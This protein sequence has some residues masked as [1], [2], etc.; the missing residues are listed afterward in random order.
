MPGIGSREA[1]ADL[2]ENELPQRAGAARQR[3]RDVDHRAAPPRDLDEAQ[4]DHI[5]A[6]LGVE[7]VAEALGHL[8]VETWV[9]GV[10]GSF[11]GMNLRRVGVA[12]RALF[13]PQQR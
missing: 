3:E 7:D 9:I 4:I 11:P 10:H 8:V 12:R 13:A 5:E 1:V 6:D 2:R